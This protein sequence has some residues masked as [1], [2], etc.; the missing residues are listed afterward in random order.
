VDAF[1][2]HTDVPRATLAWCPSRKSR[3]RRM[4]TTSISRAT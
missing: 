4:T 3:T 1:S 2:K